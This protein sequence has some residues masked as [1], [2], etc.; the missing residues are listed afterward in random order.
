[1]Y[2]VDIWDLKN[3]RGAGPNWFTGMDMSLSE[4]LARAQEWVDENGS[5]EYYKIMWH[6][7][8]CM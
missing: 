7:V 5:N 2:V 3:G 6:I 8:G 4:A 1:M